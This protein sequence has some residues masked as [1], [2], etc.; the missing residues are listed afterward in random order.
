MAENP[1]VHVPRAFPVLDGANALRRRAVGRARS[2][3]LIRWQEVEYGKGSAQQLHIWEMN[4]LA[5]RDGWPAVLLIHGGGWRQGSWQDFQ[6]FG[7]LLARKGLFVA[8][9]NYRLAPEHP[10]PAALEDVLGAIDFLRGQW[11]DVDRIALWGHSA[12]GQLALAAALQRPRHVRCAVALGAPT[13]LVQQAASEDLSDVF[14]PE[15]LRQA[16][17]LHMACESPPPMLHVHGTADRVCGI[18]HARKH[19]AARPE[20]VRLIEV[21]DGDHGLRWP[22]L[23]AMAARRK[24]VKWMLEQLDPAQRSS[25]WKRRKK[26]PKR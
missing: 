3:D 23:R 12:G 15:Q 19:Q 7:P 2:V 21:P 18:E 5:P 6:S 20:T 8:A 26:K 14:S 22:P 9:M 1:L 16:S 4:D 25:K 17:P 13:D 24:A 10:W 11:V